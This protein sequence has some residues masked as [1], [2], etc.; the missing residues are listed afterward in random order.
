MHALV[1][2]PI[3]PTSKLNQSELMLRRAHHVLSWTMHFY[4]HS[5]PPSPSSEIIIP[6]PITVPLLQVSAQLQ[7]PPVVT[8]SDDVL[9]NWAFKSPPLSD[10][11]DSTPLLAPALDNLRCLTLFTGT[12][13]EEEF[14]L[15]SARMELRGVEA[16]DLM[17]ATMDELFVGDTIALRRITQYLH[18]LGRVIDDLAALLMTVRDGCRPDVFYNDIR[19][20]FCG[21]DSSS[22]QRR[23]IF[24][25]LEDNPDLVA[26]TELSGPSAAQSS[27]V[28]VLDVFLGVDEYSHSN[29]LTGHH[30]VKPSSSSSTTATSSLESDKSKISFLTR[31]QTYMPRHHRNFLRHLSTAARPLRET[32]SDSHDTELLEAY[33]DAVSSLKRFRD[34][35]IRIVAMYIVGPSRKVADAERVESEEAQAPLK[36]TGGT[37]LVKFLKDVRDRTAA[38]VMDPK[39]E[40]L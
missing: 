23:W 25:G 24:E 4:I 22:E 38:A 19:P 14:Y 40:C 34:G 36:G 15:T 16:L 8:Y 39:S 18:A 2:M 17:R 35:H 33:N 7:L 26:P 9:Y 12:R 37:D 29:S 20:W 13:D 10:P 30:S 21:A 5:L 3:I 27:L 28:H 11:A 1:Q 31:M 6:A 32:V